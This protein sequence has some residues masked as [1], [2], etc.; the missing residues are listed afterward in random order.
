MRLQ[1]GFTLVEVL[2]AVLI[3]G[4][5]ITTS[6]AIFLERNKRLQQANELILC[7]QALA[8]EAEAR[9]RI[10]FHDL[11]QS[12]KDFVTDTEI[13]KPLGAYKAEVITVAAKQP[14]LINVTIRVTWRNGEK[15]QD[16]TVVRANTGGNNLW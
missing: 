9:R 16:L 13:L 7:Y 2:V 6:L 8:N 4:L 14:D 11:P 10:E 5:V 1:R 3:L 12:S 15:Q